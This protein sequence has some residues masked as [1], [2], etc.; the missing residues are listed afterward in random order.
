MQREVEPLERSGVEPRAAEW[1]EPEPPEEGESAV[2]EPLEKYRGGT[3][4]GLDPEEV[5]TRTEVARHL[6][7]SVFPTDKSGVLRNAADNNAP[8]GVLEL[9]TGLPEDQWFDNAQSVWQALGGGSERR[10]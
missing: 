1:R 7:P 8:D 4:P 3:P 2:P 6:E 5:D 9:L 10:P